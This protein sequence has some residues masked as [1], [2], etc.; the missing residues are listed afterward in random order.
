MFIL[1]VFFATSWL[2]TFTLFL[3]FHQSMNWGLFSFGAVCIIIAAVIAE[4]T[5]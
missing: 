4:L 3:I 2:A 1:I 5:K